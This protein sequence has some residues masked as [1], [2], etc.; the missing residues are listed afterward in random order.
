L[1]EC[2]SPDVAEAIAQKAQTAK[3]CRRI[4][5]QGLVVPVDKEKAFRDALNAIGYGMPQ[6]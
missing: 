4:G 1:I 3:L 6:V 2:L 5:E